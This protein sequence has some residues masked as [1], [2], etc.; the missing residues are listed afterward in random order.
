MTHRI[1]RTL[2]LLAAVAALSAAAAIAADLKSL[3]K[4]LH[5]VP[6]TTGNEEMLAAKVR[7]SLP[8]GLTVE[9]D[10]LGTVAVRLAGAGGPTLVLTGLDGYGHLVSGIAPDGHLTVDRPVAPPHA[11]FDAYLL[12]QPVVVSTARGPVPGVVAQPALHL[13]T[14]ER[15]RLLVEGYSLENAFIDIGARSERE[16]RAKG[17]ELLDP[18]TTV[19]LLTELAGEKWSGPS[20][21]SKAV[22]AAL[23]DAVSAPHRAAAGVEVIVAWAA[24]TKFAARGRGAR[25]PLGAARAQARWRPRRAVLVDVI[26]AGE[27]EDGPAVGRGPVLIPVGTPPLARA[28]AD[29]AAAEGL[30]LQPRTGPGSSLA[31]PFS[32]PASEAVT[33]ALPVRYLDTPSETISLRDL[34][35]LRDLLAAFLTKGEGR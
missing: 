21:G 13:L 24:Q 27:G 1:R 7:A 10:G 8:K 2:G 31:L 22:A 11:R 4:D 25:P 34:Q 33:L 28:L 12:G 17:V 9:E 26:A 14:Q 35:A 6:S 30:P 23:A 3:V 19:A 32:D 20:L 15:R 18:V 5:A 29:L 16:A